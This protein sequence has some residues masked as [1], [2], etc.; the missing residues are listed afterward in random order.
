MVSLMF[1]RA[2]G[3]ITEEKHSKSSLLGK[4]LGGG[5]EIIL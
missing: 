3:G 1:Y 5:I 4:R 2:L